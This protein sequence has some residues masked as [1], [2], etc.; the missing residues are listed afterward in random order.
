MINNQLKGYFNAPHF[1]EN[2]YVH[3]KQPN[4]MRKNG[5]AFTTQHFPNQLPTV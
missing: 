4:E 5:N 3:V 1:R 2:F